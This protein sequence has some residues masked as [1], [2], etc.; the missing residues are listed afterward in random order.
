MRWGII[1]SAASAKRRVLLA[2]RRLYDSSHGRHALLQAAQA[3]SRS[4]GRHQYG[5]GYIAKTG[6]RGDEESAP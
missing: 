3:R 5:R 2:P 4:R 1:L 6:R